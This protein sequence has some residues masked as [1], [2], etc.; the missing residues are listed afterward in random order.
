MRKEALLLV[1][2]A[3]AV[4]SK[5]IECSLCFLSMNIAVVVT[6]GVNRELATNLLG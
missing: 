6:V 1:D 3:G 5:A 4:V 2:S